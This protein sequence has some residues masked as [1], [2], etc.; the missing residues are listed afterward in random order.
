MKTTKPPKLPRFKAP[1]SMAS[2]VFKTKK[3]K[4]KTRRSL[5]TE[6]QRHINEED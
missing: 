6:L 1:K 5:K 4:A 3:D 2:K